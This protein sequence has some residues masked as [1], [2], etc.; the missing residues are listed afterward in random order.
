VR[1][2]DPDVS[3]LHLTTRRNEM[4]AISANP[5]I[6]DNHRWLKRAGLY[7]FWFFLAKGILWLVAP[8]VFYYLS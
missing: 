8:L 6:I 3:G 5:E 4:N 1:P 7:G 2:E